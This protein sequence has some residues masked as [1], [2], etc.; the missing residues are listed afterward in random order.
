[1]SKCLIGVRCSLSS[2]LDVVAL[3][4]SSYS[5]EGSAWAELCGDV[6]LMGDLARVMSG[7]GDRSVC[8]ILAA[9]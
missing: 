6:R 1:M 5:I 2:S 4:S 9:R 8:R 3:R 7:M